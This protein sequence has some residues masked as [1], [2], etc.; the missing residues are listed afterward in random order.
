MADR[1]EGEAGPDETKHI[2][3]A[4]RLALGRPPTDREVELMRTFLARAGGG[5]AAREQMARV[6]FNLNEFVYPD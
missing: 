2:D 6:I 4:Y 1:L 3:L 5:R